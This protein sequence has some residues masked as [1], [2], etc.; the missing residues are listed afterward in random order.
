[1]GGQACVLYGAAEFSRDTDFAVLA[2]APNFNCLLSAI[3]DLQAECIA[4]PSP[5]LNYLLKGHALHFRCHHPDAEGLRIDVMSKMRGLEGFR[6]LWD[7][8]TTI[9]LQDGLKVDLLSIA[10]LVKAK[11]TQHDKDW[12]MIRRLIES[13]YLQ[14]RN[15]PNPERIKFWFLEMRTPLLL[16][17]VAQQHPSE[18]LA[19]ASTRPALSAILQKDLSLCDAALQKEEA[20]E[21]ENDRLYWQPL[22]LELEALRHAGQIDKRSRT[23]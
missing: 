11:K 15:D 12:P 5:Q 1:M 7:R 2:D 6:N 13:H 17:E 16:A 20:D 9:E 8:R 3:A 4:V 23:S 14:N 18:A 22:K 10:D 19:L 21:R